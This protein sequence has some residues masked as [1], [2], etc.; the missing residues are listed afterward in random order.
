VKAV[1]KAHSSTLNDVVVSCC[2]GALRRYLLSTGEVPQ[3]PLIV[4]IPYSV[5]GDDD[6]HRWANHVT[7]I[8]AELPT[9]IDDPLQ[10]LRA[11]REQVRSARDNV[12]ALPTHLLREASN[13]IPQTLWKLS[14]KLVA[15][16]PDWIP[17][18]S[19]NVVVANSRGPAK[20]VEMTGARVAG[21]W[22]VAFLTP[23]VGL[24]ITVQSY[25]DRL[26]VGIMGCPDLLPDLSPL[27]D[28]L[29]AALDDLATASGVTTVPARHP[30]PIHPHQAS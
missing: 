6:K 30:Y 20:P 18:A 28:H 2:A 19:W 23:G 3:E 26:C 24:N 12:E 4:C 29:V 16:G 25:T 5:R 27:P 13:F 15:K 21:L 9:N 22:P 1:A 14:V 17:G 8:F 7:T 10:Q 11:V